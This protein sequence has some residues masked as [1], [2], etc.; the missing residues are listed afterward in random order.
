MRNCRLKQS[1]KDFWNVKL[2][3]EYINRTKTIFQTFLQDQKKEGKIRVILNLKQFNEN[4]V[5]H[6]HFE[7]ETLKS[8]VNAMRPNCYFGSEDL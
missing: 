8:A 6:I 3:K 4:Y 7:M 1:C 5:E 2:L